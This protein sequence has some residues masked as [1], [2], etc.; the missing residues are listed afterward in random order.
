M[1]F[2]PTLVA[3]DRNTGPIWFQELRPASGRGCEPILDTSAGVGF[4]AE[5]GGRAN[6]WLKRR[7]PDAG[8]IA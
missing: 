1:S 8:S 3:A 6:A 7:R 2:Q 4:T 5:D